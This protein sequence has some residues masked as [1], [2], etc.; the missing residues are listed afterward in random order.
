MKSMKLL[1]IIAL[2]ALVISACTLVPNH[3]E[4]ADVTGIWQAIENAPY[5]EGRLNIGYEN[6][7]D[8]EKLAEALDAEIVL[9]IPQ[10][11]AA[12]I[13]FDGKLVDIKDELL[14]VVR[15]K[16][17]ALRYIEPS[18]ERELDEPL[19]SPDVLKELGM[20][21]FTVTE[22][23]T[24][25]IPDLME[26]VWGVEKIGAPEAWSLG[27]DGSGIIVAVIDTGIDSTHPDLEGQVAM[28]YDP[29]L[30]T[31]VATNI[32]YSFEAHGTHV[33]GTI[34]AK[35]DGIG[36]TGVAP[37]AKL[38]DIPIFQPGYIGDEYVASGIV[39][40]VDHGAN[41]L[42]N[43]WGGK[44]YSSMLHDAITYAYVNNV[45]F[46]NSAGNERVDEIGSPKMYP[47]V[48]VVAAS[49]AVDGVTNFSSRSRKISVAAPGDYTVLSTVP[50]W[51]EDEFV[52]DSYPYAFYGG[53]SMACPHVSG[54][55][56]LLMQ[57]YS[58]EE[59]VLNPYQYRKILERGAV[60]ILEP[61]FDLA[62]G[63]GRL[64][65]SGSLAVD[66]DSIGNGGEVVF[67]ALSRRTYADGSKEPL[68]GVYVTLIPHDP[69]LPIYTAKT[70]GDGYAPFIGIDPGMYDVYFGNGDPFDPYSWMY[71]GGRMAEQHGYSWKDFEV[72]EGTAWYAV[73]AEFSS[74]PKVVVENIQFY[75]LDGTPVDVSEV[76]VIAFN[77]KA[78]NVI[79][80]DEFSTTIFFDGGSFTLPDN[81][82][83]PLYEFYIIPVLEVDD[84]EDYYAVVSGYVE[85]DND[86]DRRVFFEV[87]MDGGGALI[88]DGWMYYFT[89]F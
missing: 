28:R 67:K 2:L 76:P 1:V 77:I 32:D 61:G 7:S 74:K 25:G 49:T 84:L 62:S 23:A 69:W 48:V 34:A 79:T 60:D 13:R 85:Y 33:A 15:N 57:K 10:I 66:P 17:L 19:K 58:E 36:V 72:T 4:K 39:W 11:K 45:I 78:I 6:Y 88:T 53:T 40:A 75:T 5:Y 87:Y 41:I 18:Y 89:A 20:P 63:W 12:S 83:P 9:D 22:V 35:D 68:N 8:V 31:E 3:E 14:D 46:V 44:G 86:A 51:D 56:A 73:P 59:E 52:F 24:E 26:F 47:G 80:A 42:S 65:V 54:A 55:L 37:G 29:L 30:G 50:L 27:Y 16:D 21:S 82:P 43:S 81:A 70:F 64:D 71:Y 38:M